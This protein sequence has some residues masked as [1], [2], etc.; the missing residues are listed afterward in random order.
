MKNTYIKEVVSGVISFSVLLSGVSVFA[1]TGTTTPQPT[2]YRERAEAR[3]EMRDIRRDARTEME[4]R[5]EQFRKDTEMKRE[6]V[7]KQ[8]ETKRTQF[9][10]K[11]KTIKDEKKRVSVERLNENLAKINTKSI[12]HF[13]EV[14]DKQDEI[15]A[16]ISSRIAKLESEGASTTVPVATLKADLLTAQNAISVARGAV[17]VQTTKS[18]TVAITTEANLKMDVSTVR[19]ALETDLKAVRDSVKASQE[20]LRKV[21]R[22]LAP[23]PAANTQN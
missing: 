18:Y 21:A 13:T 16:N 10:E 8:M 6:E 11:V 7:K 1:Q 15:A 14:L 17:L 4:S 20:A 5:R 12:E 22:A 2:L 19:K 9:A 23:A 3:E